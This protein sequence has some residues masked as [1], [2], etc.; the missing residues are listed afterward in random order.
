MIN[1]GQEYVLMSQNCDLSFLSA[2]VADTNTV[3]KITVESEVQHTMKHTR[4]N[5]YEKKNPAG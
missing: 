5:V 1:V 4:T 2:K 3:L